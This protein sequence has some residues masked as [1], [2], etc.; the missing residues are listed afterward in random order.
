MMANWL[1]KEEPSHYSF[2]RLLGDKKT[3]WDGVENNLA[4]IHL[5]NSVLIT[6]YSVLGTR[7]SV[8]GTLFSELVANTFIWFPSTSE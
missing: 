6:R 3:V 7:Y 8:L 5:R 2:D 4:L 1:F